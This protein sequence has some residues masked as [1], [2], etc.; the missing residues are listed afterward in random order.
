MYPSG[1]LHIQDL[2]LPYVPEYNAHISFKHGTGNSIPLY[3]CLHEI[4][5]SGLLFQPSGM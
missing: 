1:R 4:P 3:I 2:L 5:F